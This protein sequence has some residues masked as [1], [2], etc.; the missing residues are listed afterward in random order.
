MNLNLIRWPREQCQKN[1]GL[2]TQEFFFSLHLQKWGAPQ[3]FITREMKFLQDWQKRGRLRRVHLSPGCCLRRRSSLKEPKDGTT[4][5]ATAEE[6]RQLKFLTRPLLKQDS[7]E[8]HSANS[9]NFLQRSIHRLIF[10]RG[11]MFFR[12]ASGSGQS[13]PTPPLC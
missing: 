7:A 2:Q 8:M 10:Q 13:R 12:Q 4:S 11:E 1:L 5:G 6:R 3:R 9:S